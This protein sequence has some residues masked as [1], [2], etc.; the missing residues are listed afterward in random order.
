MFRNDSFTDN[1]HGKYNG[2][3]G[4]GVSLPPPEDG[5]RSGFRNV[6]FLSYL[7]FRT[8]DELHKS[9]DSEC[10]TSSVRYLVFLSS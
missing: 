1:V 6:M 8:M 10:Y 3:N 2:P 4:I 5:N 9:S 7:E